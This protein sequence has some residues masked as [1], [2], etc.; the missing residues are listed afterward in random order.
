MNRATDEDLGLPPDEI[1][2]TRR[3]VTAWVLLVLLCLVALM[4]AADSGE[5]PKVTLAP[6]TVQMADPLPCA[7]DPEVRLIY[8]EQGVLCRGG[9]R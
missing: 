2:A 6:V 1:R 9:G 5:T 3:N 8:Q 4:W 7:D